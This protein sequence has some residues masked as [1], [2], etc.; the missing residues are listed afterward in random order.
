[1]EFCNQKHY[2]LTSC[3]YLFRRRRATSHPHSPMGA[4][5]PNGTQV[6]QAS[7]QAGYLQTRYV[8]GSLLL[9][10]LLI[11][12]MMCPLFT[13]PRYFEHPLSVATSAMLAANGNTEP[14]SAGNEDESPGN[15]VALNMNHLGSSHHHIQ[16]ANHSSGSTTYLYEYYKVPEKDPGSVQWM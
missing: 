8:N 11:F 15:T 9:F 6:L 16:Q 13:P 3:L 10:H 4:S 2:I 5:D 12:T 7:S 14:N 1:M